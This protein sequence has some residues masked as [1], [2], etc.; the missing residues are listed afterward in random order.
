VGLLLAGAVSAGA[1]PIEF[2]FTAV[3]F[4]NVGGIPAGTP[5]VGS[6]VFE[7]TTPGQLPFPGQRLDY[8]GAI[9]SLS[10]ALG[11]AMFSAS[12]GTNVIVVD[13]GTLGDGYEVTVSVN[14]GSLGSGLFDL[15]LVD[16]HQAMLSSTT[17]PLVPPLLSDAELRA[18]VIRVDGGDQINA[19]LTSLFVI[20]EPSSLRL[21]ALG[22][23][24]AS[25]MRRR[26]Y[27]SRSR[28][29]S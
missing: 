26:R 14:S 5:I 12:V 1:A 4:S 21:V 23:L 25:A 18:V 11:A 16:A 20:A 15:L 2:G 17:L 28:W 22:M 24:V 7:S 3:V 29:S 9:S 19:D 27:D 6:Y 10:F 8:P 13:N